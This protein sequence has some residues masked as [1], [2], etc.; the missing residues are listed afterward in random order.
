ME[1]SADHSIRVD[2]T[3]SV[4]AQAT[5]GCGVGNPVLFRVEGE[6]DGLRIIQ[7]PI[8]WAAKTI[9]SERMRLVELLRRVGV[10]RVPDV[11][12]AIR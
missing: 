5:A 12:P 11:E 4:G 1:W 10:K 3:R 6:T 9:Q 8:E 7:T 2:A